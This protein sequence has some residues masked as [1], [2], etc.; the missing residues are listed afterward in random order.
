MLREI[1]T[2]ARRGDKRTVEKGANLLLQEYYDLKGSLDEP[3]KISRRDALKMC[4]EGTERMLE[5]L[6]KSGL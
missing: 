3:L 6:E 5:V 2:A 4:E 1:L